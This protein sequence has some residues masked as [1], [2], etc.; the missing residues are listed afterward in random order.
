MKKL[1]ILLFLSFTISGYTYAAGSSGGDGD[2]LKKTDYQKAVTLIKSA[3]KF[4]KKGKTDKAMKK[5]QEAK[6]LL[7]LSNKTKPNVI[8]MHRRNAKQS[9][10]SIKLT[11]ILKP[12]ITIITH[13]I[14]NIPR[15]NAKFLKK[16]A[17]NVI[18]I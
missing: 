13:G 3:K 6:K 15:Y 2:G 17:V 1:L 10:P 16:G 4:E 5:Y 9:I 8:R 14:K 18:S 11:S 12:V 7:I